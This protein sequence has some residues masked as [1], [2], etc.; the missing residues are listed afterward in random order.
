MPR[1][2]NTKP[3][4]A[5]AKTAQAKRDAAAVTH[6]EAVMR[7]PGT[8]YVVLSFDGPVDPE[9]LADAA[10]RLAR[11]DKVPVILGGDGLTTAELNDDYARDTYEKVQEKQ[12]QWGEAF[13]AAI[14]AA[15]A[16]ALGEQS[17]AI[18]SADEDDDGG[19]D[20]DEPEPEPEPEPAEIILA[21]LRE[22]GPGSPQDIAAATGLPRRTTTVELV[23]M[24]NAGTVHKNGLAY[25]VSAA[26]AEA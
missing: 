7:I 21:H 16:F 2:A 18:E 8:P 6:A 4:P 10:D 1:A 24:T 19:I 13:G 17:G 25:A 22:H 5:A 15:D 3:D 12:A 14:D 11:R 26:S 20:E 9:R 23:R